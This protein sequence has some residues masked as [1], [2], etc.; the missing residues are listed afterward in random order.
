MAAVGGAS[1]AASTRTASAAL[2][3]TITG[4]RVYIKSQAVIIA[5]ETTAIAAME[6]TV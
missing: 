5:V 3:W 6:V 1:S 2:V 4:K